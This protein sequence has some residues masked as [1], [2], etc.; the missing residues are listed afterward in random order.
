MPEPIVLP[1]MASSPTTLNADM[2]LPSGG[3]AHVQVPVGMSD[4]DG[5]AFVAFALQVA[6]ASQ[7]ASSPGSIVQ[8][9]GALPK[10]PSA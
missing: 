5:F 8:V 10:E 3:Q 6:I 1:G 9:H 4:R 7:R 2:P